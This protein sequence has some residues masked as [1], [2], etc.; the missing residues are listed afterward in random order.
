MCSASH[1]LLVLSTFFLAVAL[2]GNLAALIGPSW[3]ESGVLKGGRRGTLRQGL[4]LYD[5][6]WEDKGENWEARPSLM[7]LTEDGRGRFAWPHCE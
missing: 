1:V 5:M 4:L 2:C 6:K 3:M 7:Q